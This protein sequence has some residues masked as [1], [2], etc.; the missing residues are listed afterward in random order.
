M[1][2]ILVIIMWGS[3]AATSQHIEF[4]SK[5]NCENAKDDIK[6]DEKIGKIHYV[7]AYCVPK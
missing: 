6:N 3:S 2:Y 7:Y 4:S 1:T 5:D